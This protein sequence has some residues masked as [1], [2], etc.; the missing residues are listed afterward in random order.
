MNARQYLARARRRL[1]TLGEESAPE[2]KLCRELLLRFLAAINGRDVPAMV[3]LLAGEQPVSVREA[4]PVRMRGACAN[5]AWYRPA[6][7]A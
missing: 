5:D 2:E 4:A 6:L 7:M 3:S 1:R